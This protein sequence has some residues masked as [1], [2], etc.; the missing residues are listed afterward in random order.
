MY[1]SALFERDA[2]AVPG[3]TNMDF[4]GSSP[5]RSF[6]CFSGETLVLNPSVTPVW[7]T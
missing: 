4:E 1:T 6:S 2:P 5:I 7:R 3:E